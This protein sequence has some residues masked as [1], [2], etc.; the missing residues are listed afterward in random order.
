[1][2]LAGGPEANIVVIPTAGRS[3]RYAP[4]WIGLKPFYDAGARHVTVLHT[5]SPAEADSDAFAEVLRAA[6]GVWLTGGRPWRL[7]DAYH[8]TRVEDELH[9]LLARGGV[10]GGTSAGASIMASYLVRGA[11]A[12][13]EIVMTS[14]YDSGFDFLHGTAVD[15]HIFVRARERDLVDVLEANPGLLGIGLDEGAALVVQGDRAEVIGERTVAIYDPHAGRGGY[16]VL[17]PGITYDLGAR[18]WEVE[19]VDPAALGEDQREPVSDGSHDR[20]GS[21]APRQ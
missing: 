5:R 12:G 18:R 3:E 14:E 21:R 8:R 15:Q 16:A 9:L 2:E 20:E 1:M 13:N 11:P 6:H 19:D 7:V 17:W 10:I 4:G